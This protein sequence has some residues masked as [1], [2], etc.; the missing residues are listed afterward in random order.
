MHH[1][2]NHFPSLPL[3]HFSNPKFHHYPSNFFHFTHLTQRIKQIH[4]TS[5][6]PPSTP[7]LN[8]K[9]FLQI[10]YFQPNHLFQH[11][12]STKTIQMIP[13]NKQTH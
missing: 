2:L 7:T 1:S 8:T 13:Q 3:T 11:I 9:N 12:T 4:K 5:S 10:F 6:S